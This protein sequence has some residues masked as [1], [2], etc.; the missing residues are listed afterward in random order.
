MINL[1]YNRIKIVSSL[2]G[3][4][5]ANISNLFRNDKIAF[6]IKIILIRSKGIFSVKPS[7]VT[8]NVLI[9]YDTAHISENE[10][11]IIL[12]KC[13]NIKSKLKIAEDVNNGSLCK[14]IFH[15]LNPLSLFEK[16]RAKEIY[17]NEY[18]G[19]KKIINISLIMSGITLLVTN[20][21]SKAFSVFIL[22]YP[23]I[24][25]SIALVSCYYASSKLKYNG[26]YFK[27][28]HSFYLIKDV[29]TLLIDSSL[30]LN[31]FYKYNKSL[32]HLDRMDF[33]KLI[34]LKQLENPV[35][36]RMKSI[37]EN[38]RLLGISNISIIGNCKNVVINYISYYLG[39]DIL[40]YEVLK[41]NANYGFN[42]KTKEKEAFLVTN[43]FLGEF[44]EYLYHD[45]VICVYKNYAAMTDMLKG[46]INF[47]YNYM[48][49]LPLIIELSH[50]CS[51]I[52]IQTK[53]VALTL[54]IIGMLLSIMDYLNPLKSI[55]FYSFNTLISIL[56]LKFRL[57]LY[58][59]EKNN[60]LSYV[61]HKLY[62]YKLIY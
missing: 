10:I 36:D 39:I 7:K 33:E 56:T 2:P 40:D 21:I 45:L 59:I 53:N 1:N 62:F 44:Q 20:S 49:K 48:D 50:F 37:I 31:K 29:N 55:I 51:E 23:G 58:N 32:S 16:K 15:A 3:R 24:L 4:L 8:G 60:N 57:K 52:D 61:K 27:D 41:Y 43:E 46:N 26:I 28:Y 34:I 11:I 13:L 9:N 47:K 18:I 17:R 35:S 6:N 5:R 42:N 22:G 25:F 30:F 38:I 54:N 12:D 19:S 14:I